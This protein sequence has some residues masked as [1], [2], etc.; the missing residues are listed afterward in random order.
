MVFYAPFLA[1]CTP[2]YLHDTYTS[3]TLET[4]LADRHHLGGGR[5]GIAHE[6]L[7][8]L[9]DADVVGLWAD[10]KCDMY[11]GLNSNQATDHG[12]GVV[13]HKEKIG[14]SE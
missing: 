10:I 5:I 9:V 3:K 13:Y 7:K 14:K 4:F 12:H 2:D 11:K 6:I 8:L 1:I